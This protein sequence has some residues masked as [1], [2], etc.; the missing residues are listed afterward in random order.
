MRLGSMRGMPGKRDTELQGQYAGA[1]EA[2]SGWCMCGRAMAT[3][4]GSKCAV[5]QDEAKGRR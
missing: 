2:A 4:G 3:G 1:C 5:E